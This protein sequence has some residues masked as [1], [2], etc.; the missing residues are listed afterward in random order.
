MFDYVKN[1]PINVG[2]LNSC[3]KA[4]VA[5]KLRY[6]NDPEGISPVTLYGEK[7]LMF[8]NGCTSLNKNSKEYFA[9]PWKIA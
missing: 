6:P 5:D 4:Y 1:Y 9:H 8:C 2:V 7:N 3:T